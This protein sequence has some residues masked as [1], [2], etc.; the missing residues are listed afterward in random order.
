MRRLRGESTLPWVCIG[1]FNEILRQ[2]EQMGPNTRD[3][4]QIA[5]FQEAVDVCGL[6]DLGYKGLDWTFEKR[7][8]GGQYC[9]VRLDRAL[10][11]SSWSS[12]FPFASVEH[13]TAAKSDHS[14]ILLLNDLEVGN[15]R[16]NINKPFRYECAWETDSRFAA[17][18]EAAWNEDG[19]A[20]SVSKL[21][22]KLHSVSSAMTRWGRHTFG[23]VRMELRSLRRQLALLR[24]ESTRM[25]PS[26]EEKAIED[27]MIELAYREEIMARQRSRITWLSEGDRNTEFF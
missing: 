10:A 5:G 23:S 7:V 27:R 13:L 15:R 17:T 24:E 22:N 20:G 19:P 2:E 26:Q 18:V 6:L 3:S 21:A 14:P 16:M 11:T 1:D 12:L 8:T 4:S 9:R 25:G